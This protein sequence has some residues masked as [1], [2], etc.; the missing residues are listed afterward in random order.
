MIFKVLGEI[1]IIIRAAAIPCKVLLMHLEI[2]LIYEDSII[3][4]F[5]FKVVLP[6]GGCA[7]ADAILGS[8]IGENPI[9]LWIE[10]MQVSLA[11]I[12]IENE[13][14]CGGRGPPGGRRWQ[15]TPVV[16]V[17]PVVLITKVGDQDVQ[18]GP[19]LASLKVEGGEATLGAGQEAALLPGAEGHIKISDISRLGLHDDP[20]VSYAA[21]RIILGAH[22]VGIDFVR[23]FGGANPVAPV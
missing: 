1:E 22:S 7:V 18:V 20:P 11:E 19:V 4:E 9:D 13:E 14:I 5:H 15:L 16:I 12:I 3:G 17:P 10:T 8:T 21:I 23:E 6:E 2:C